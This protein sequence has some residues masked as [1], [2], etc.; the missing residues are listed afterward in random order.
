MT[1]KY[2]LNA[3]T[4]MASVGSVYLNFGLWALSLLPA[5]LVVKNVGVTLGD[6]KIQRE[7]RVD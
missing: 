1:C 3:V 4:I 6:K 2:G 7:A 5:W